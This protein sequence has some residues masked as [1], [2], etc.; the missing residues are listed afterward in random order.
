MITLV[1][2]SGLKAALSV[3]RELAWVL[4]GQ[5]IG[6]LGAIVG[7]RLLT[8]AL[9]PATYGEFALGI[10]TATL[11]FQV[12]LGP[13]VNAYE[14]HYAQSQETGRGVE[15]FR[16]VGR[17]TLRASAIIVLVGGGIATVIALVGE[18]RWLPL[19]VAG[20]MFALPSGLESVLDTVQ[21][22]AR[23]RGTVAFHQALRQWIRPILA[24][25][26]LSAIAAT[27]TVGIFA[28][29]LASLV[30]LCSQFWFFRRTAPR[31][32]PSP[33]S[34]GGWSPLEIQM[35]AYA[36]PFGV[37]GLFTW[38]QMSSDRWALQLVGSSDE[39]G[40]YAIVMQLGAYPV[41]LL[42]AMLSQ[43][44]APIIF[45]KAGLGSDDVRVKTAMQLCF[46][47]AG[48]ILLVT[49][50]LSIG[51]LLFHERLFTLLVGPQYRAVS[52]LLP[53]AILSSGVFVCGQMLSLMPM[54]LANSQALLVPKIW[55]AVL[56]I[57]L[58]I[59]GAYLYGPLGVL[60]AG[61]VFALCYSVWVALLTRSLLASRQ[62]SVSIAPA[63]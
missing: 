39:V 19:V 48:A 37:W 5:L 22:A 41:T 53:L 1:R 17:L 3:W 33:S 2:Q 43:L 57:G 7:V 40:L 14:R 54:A 35:L 38:M 45:A 18:T 49:F 30:V 24:V 32:T 6:A 31:E 8:M 9:A 51:A 46:A 20:L 60:L 62:D 63:R 26:M 4:T 28:Y 42:G 47:V 11:A 27:S 50:F 58:N 36:L 52:Y 10:T 13:L 55:T 34:F 12:I 23:R 21:N 61:L 25:V 44:A 15:Y 16:A 59:I 56:A 29:A